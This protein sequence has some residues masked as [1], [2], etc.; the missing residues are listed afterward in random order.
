MIV[1]YTC[2]QLWS[3]TVE[4]RGI[5]GTTRTGLTQSAKQASWNSL[6]VT[7][8]SGSQYGSDIGPVHICY[9]CVAWVF[10]WDSY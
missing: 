6:R 8:Q 1:S 7:G 2:R 4:T 3:R 5:Q 10:L 9:D